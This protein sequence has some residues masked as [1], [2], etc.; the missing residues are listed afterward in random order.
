MRLPGEKQGKKDRKAASYAR[1]CN[2]CHKY[3][4]SD[5]HGS[6][7]DEQSGKCALQARQNCSVSYFLRQCVHDSL[8]RFPKCLDRSVAPAYSGRIPAGE[9][10]SGYSSVGSTGYAGDILRHLEWKFGVFHVFVYTGVVVP[11]IPRFHSI[12]IKGR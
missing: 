9:T 3:L 10:L 12:S 1:Q 7:R 8:C 11:V 5:K 4:E 6:S 2:T